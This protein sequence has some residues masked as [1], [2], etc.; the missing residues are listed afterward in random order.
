MGSI[1]NFLAPWSQQI[2]SIF[3]IVVGLLFLEHGTSKYISL[4]ISPL[5]G[6]NPTTLS[7]INGFIELIGGALIVLGLFTRPVAFILSGDMAIAYFISHAPRGFFPLLNGGEL[8]ILY[9]FAFLYFA[10]AGGG[11]WSIDRLWESK[12]S[13]GSAT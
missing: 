8:A 5:T 9:C 4:P 2:L 13:Q 1:F 7:G 11:L 12:P 10:A 3:R 6:V